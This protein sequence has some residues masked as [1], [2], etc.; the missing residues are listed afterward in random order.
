MLRAW[1]WGLSG[2]LIAESRKYMNAWLKSDTC[3]Y[4]E[5]QCTKLHELVAEIKGLTRQVGHEFSPEQHK[6]SQS[7]FC[8]AKA[9]CSI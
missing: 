7:P 9:R 4:P 6:I 8:C 3:T 1:G 5:C 2:A